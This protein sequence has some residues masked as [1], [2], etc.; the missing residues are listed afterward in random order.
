MVVKDEHAGGG[1]LHIVPILTCPNFFSQ[2][3][4]PNRTTPKGSSTTTFIQHAWN[5]TKTSLQETD[6]Q[7]GGL[8][9]QQL[10][11]HTGARWLEGISW[12]R[13]WGPEVQAACSPVCTL[14]RNHSGCKDSSNYDLV[15]CVVRSRREHSTENIFV[16][17]L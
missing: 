7:P 10:R 3:P 5:G 8:P 16:S 4:K 6:V 14:C 15:W 1:L 12:S 11:V 2:Q 13:G 9:P 17:S